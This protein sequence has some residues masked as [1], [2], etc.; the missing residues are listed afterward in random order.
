MP[1]HFTTL[2][3]VDQQ[4]IDRMYAEYAPVF[5]LTTGRS[6]SKFLALL[7]NQSPQICAYHEPRPTLQYF[8]HEVYHQQDQREKL[9]AMFN[10]ARLELLLE[11]YISGKIFV[12]ANQS[13]TFFAPVISEVLPQAKF[14]HLTR[15][16][17]DFVRSAV[18]KGWY[19]KDSIWESGRVRMANDQ[20]WNSLDQIA[21]LCW[22]W[23]NTHQFIEAAKQH[24]SPDR[25]LTIGMEDLVTE[26]SQVHALFEFIGAAAI[27]DAEIPTHQTTRRNKLVI[28]PDEP[29]NLQKLPHFP[30]YPLWDAQKKKTLRTYC[31]D[32]SDRYGYAIPLPPT[33]PPL[34]PRI[35]VVIPNYN[36]G[37]Y[38]KECLDS[39]LQQTYPHL[40]I[41]VCDDGSTDDSAAIIHQYEQRYPGQIKGIYLDRQHGVSFARNTAIRQATGEYLT[42][43]DSD[44]YYANPQKLAQEMALIQ[45]YKQEKQQNII[46]FSDI[47]LVDEAGHVM[48]SQA[49]SQGIGEGQIFERILTWACMIPR[50]FVA[51]K[52]AYTQVDGFDEAFLIFQTW[53]LKLHLARYY[54]FYYT[55]VPG[56]AYRQHQAGLSS[57]PFRDQNRY[58]WQI[59]NNYLPLASPADQAALRDKFTAFMQARQQ[60]YRDYLIFRM[61]QKTLA[62]NRLHA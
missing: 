56:T 24:L 42:T 23:H 37:K 62:E 27:P 11:T 50:D 52:D 39:V 17:G 54:E 43:L 46:A 40:E 60:E 19:Q 22:L 49:M 16:P 33:A 12:E 47:M 10:A 8:P 18:R 57:Q 1:M 48:R 3:H 25:A 13:L 21:Q 58:L 41:L 20:T 31:A 45:H 28:S 29:P 44:D 34:Q 6:G 53:E 35:S 4:T 32:L 26:V 55:G 14:I 61:N 36:G 59:F 2:H 15:H 5:V 7:L 38:L 51:S 9:T 30:T